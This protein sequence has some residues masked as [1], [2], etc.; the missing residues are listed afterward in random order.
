MR[1]WKFF[2]VVD[3]DAVWKFV[4][5]RMKNK[6]QDDEYKVDGGRGVGGDEEK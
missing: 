4:I 1:T 2:A 5:K 6:Q 3:V